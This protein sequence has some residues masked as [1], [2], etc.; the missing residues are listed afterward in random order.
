MDIS[1]DIIIQLYKYGGS[2][3]ARII[4]L[5]GV[6][7]VGKTTTLLLLADRLKSLGANEKSR[8]P[9]FNSRRDIAV[10]TEYKGKTI[11]IVTAGDT[12]DSLQE[13][14]NHLGNDCDIYIFACRTGGKPK[15]WIDTMF[16]GCEII[17]FEKWYIYSN[18]INSLTP[19]F[20]AMANEDQIRSLI[21]L[22]SS[23]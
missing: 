11:G 5:R 10:K 19:V 21:A 4:K 13:G 9:I 6:A 12:E 14:Y 23:L 7:Q 2:K 18:T 16:S 15:C 17:T 3:M 20:Q 8:Q 1:A 22:I